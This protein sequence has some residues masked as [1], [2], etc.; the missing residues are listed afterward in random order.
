MY[1][2]RDDLRE[3]LKDVQKQMMA[4]KQEVSSSDTDSIEDSDDDSESK[5][6]ISSLQYPFYWVPITHNYWLL[7]TFA[8]FAF[9][10]Q[11]FF[12]SCA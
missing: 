8:V 5:S 9:S 11:V 6:H 1:L 3:H 7:E 12:Q 2:Y 10:Q 4:Q